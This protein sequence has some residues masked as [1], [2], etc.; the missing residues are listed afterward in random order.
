MGLCLGAV[1]GVQCRAYILLENFCFLDFLGA[2]FSLLVDEGVGGG[3][4]VALN[5]WLKIYLSILI[6]V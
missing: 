4:F 5:F 6:V 2:H 1:Y 3:D